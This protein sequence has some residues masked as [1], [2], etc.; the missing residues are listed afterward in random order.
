MTE[1]RLQNTLSVF[2]ILAHFSILLMVLGLRLCGGLTTPEFTTTMA[3]IVPMLAALT[4][5][6]VTYALGAKTPKK[7][8]ASTAHLPAIYVFTAL[9]FPILFVLVIAVLVGLKVYSV[10]SSFDDFKMAIASVQ[11]IFGGYTGKV[12][13]S[14]FKKG[15]V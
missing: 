12:M 7:G 10:F 15:T 8:A 13:G 2:L 11:T 3:I 4:G 5:F 14:L 1:S 9:F 6:A